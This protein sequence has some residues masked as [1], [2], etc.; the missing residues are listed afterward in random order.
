M[1]FSTRSV[2]LDEWRSSE[3]FQTRT[4]G[5]QILS[6]T[7]GASPSVLQ[8]QCHIFDGLSPRYACIYASNHE[9]LGDDISAYSVG[10]ALSSDNWTNTSHW[11]LVLLLMQFLLVDWS[12]TLLIFYNRNKPLSYNIIIIGKVYDSCLIKQVFSN[13]KTYHGKAITDPN[14]IPTIWTFRNHICLTVHS[15]NICWTFTNWTSTIPG[16]SQK[17]KPRSACHF[18]NPLW[19][20]NMCL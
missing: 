14:T 5:W 19:D 12:K 10:R 3:T 1:A 17:L 2:T 16:S 20:R 6:T 4:R 11:L 7:L 8:N 13:S 18:H 15:Q 9:N